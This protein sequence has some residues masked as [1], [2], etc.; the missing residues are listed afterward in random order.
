M[1]LK[2]IK[3]G[4]EVRTIP[5]DDGGSFMVVRH[6]DMGPEHDVE[7]MRYMRFDDKHVIKQEYQERA[8]QLKDKYSQYLYGV[9]PLKIVFMV[10]EAWEPSEKASKNSAWKIDITKAP[11]LFRDITPYEYIIKMRLHWLDQWSDAQINAAIMSQLLRINPEDGSIYKYTED[12]HSRM[13]ATFG[14]G[15]L[16]PKTTIA[17][18]LKEDVKIIGFKEASGQVTMD[19]LPEEAD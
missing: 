9:W 10:D 12:F 1:E 6:G 19:E 17:D 7:D 5:L 18:L 13:L 14:A 11:A 16:E 8:R 4:E 3:N 15:Y 2:L